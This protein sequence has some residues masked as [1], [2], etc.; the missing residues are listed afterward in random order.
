LIDLLGEIVAVSNKVSMDYVRVDK[1]TMD[2]QPR[3]YLQ[4]DGNNSI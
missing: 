1:I 4:K 3:E 2:R